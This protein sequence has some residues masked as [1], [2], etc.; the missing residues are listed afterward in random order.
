MYYFQ[1]I[2]HEQEFGSYTDV[3]THETKNFLRKLKI[4]ANF[5]NSPIFLRYI[6]I[7]GVGGEVV[8]KGKNWIIFILISNFI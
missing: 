3:R 5:A 6:L 7:E 2:L 4:F 8:F 1:I